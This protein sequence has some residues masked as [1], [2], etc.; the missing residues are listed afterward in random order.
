VELKKQE[1]KGIHDF[2]CDLS[3]GDSSLSARVSEEKVI[4]L[5]VDRRDFIRLF[6]TGAL[7]SASSCVRRPVEKIV[8]YVDQPTNQ[9][10]GVAVHYAT[11]CGECTSACGVFVKTREGLPV[12][13]EGNKK[14]LVSQGALCALGQSA[15][16]GLYHPERQKSPY[17][18]SEDGKQKKLVWQD[19][20]ESIVI[21]LRSKKRVAILTSGATG[22]RHKFFRAFLQ[23]IG[24]SHENLYTYESNSLLSSLTSAH[25]IAFG[26]ERIPRVDFSEAELIIGISS[27]FIES[28]VSSVYYSKEFSRSQNYHKGHK[29]TFIQF[30][31]VLTLTGA[32][33]DKR[34]LIPPKQEFLVA[35]SLLK[36]IVHHP[37][38]KGTNEDYKKITKILEKNRKILLESEK[39]IDLNRVIFKTLAD[40]LLRHSSVVIGGGSTAYDENATRLQLV[41]ILINRV[42][43]AY[44]NI[45]D[46]SRKWF[47]PPVQPGDMERF[48][49]DAP[50]FDAVFIVETNPNFTLPESWGFSKVLKKVKT[51]VSI[52]SMP[53][54]TDDL[55][56]F[57]LPSHHYLESWGDEH[58]F[59]GYRSLR[60]PVVRP[61]TDSRQA[62]DIFLQI[63]DRL[64]KSMGYSSY[65]EFLR[66]EW[67]FI[68]RKIPLVDSFDLFFK[69]VQ[70]NGFHVESPQKVSSP[71]LLNFRELDDFKIPIRLRQMQLCSPFDVRLKDG[72]GASRPIL[73][74]VGDSLTTIAWDSWLALHPK[75]AKKLN[76]RRN[77]L[78]KIES[79]YG[80]FHVSVLP[81][82]GIHP[83]VAMIPRGNGRRGKHSKVSDGVGVDPV[84]IFDH[85]SDPLAGTPVTTGL[86]VKITSIKKTHTLAAMQK[87]GSSDLSRRPDIVR[88]MTVERAK[89]REG[90]RKDLDTIPDLYPKLKASEYRWGLSIDLSRCTGCSACMVACSLENNIPQ[91]GRKQILLGREMHWIRLDRYFEGD[92]VSNPMVT[93]QP[94]MCIQ[95]AH[96]P[97]EGVCPVFATTHDP[98][99]INAMTYNRCVGTRYCANACPIKV[100]RFNWWKHEWGVISDDPK[101][102][103]PRVLNPD[104]TV[105]SAGV[106]EKCS[107]CYQR[108]R[109]AKH[110][111]KLRATEGKLHEKEFVQTACQQTCPSDAIEFG[112]L[113]DPHTRIS[114]ARKNQRAYLL[115]GGNPEQGE[116]GLKLLPSVNYQAKVVYSRK[117]KALHKDKGH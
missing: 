57:V 82:P 28:G 32:K 108:L 61:I 29:G 1:D 93:F 105:R 13:T 71:S 60:Q 106:M 54:E 88:F 86:E 91:V 73:Q 4:P 23:K 16:Q 64:G 24:L 116:Y 104:V 101:S 10:P 51:V 36:E 75:T 90:I 115:L 17:H 15:L 5:E 59:R 92:D 113:N 8:P 44:D 89:E 34:H 117:V 85:H 12:K 84:A 55:A 20:L 63:A 56:N 26:V 107:F 47:N 9:V 45:I 43:G 33:A 96:A 6:S 111:Q 87:S 50:K 67:K 102:R 76:L 100:R 62:E 11:V 35:L 14:D 58:V 114:Q 2:Y 42:I 52:Q 74:E 98:E 7:L 68:Y 19:I 69:K 81:F 78:V 48:I 39:I 38:K 95:C 83:D 77:D 80:N 103:N 65:Y 46:L 79:K 49:V 109:D 53:N 94:V 112:N 27:D 110:E 99:G 70:K 66:E 30:E 72:R 31:S 97:C 41:I 22:S 37:L 25:K 40:R 21:N 3:E 18:V